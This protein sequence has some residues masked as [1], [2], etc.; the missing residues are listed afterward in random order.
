MSYGYGKREDAAPSANGG[1]SREELPARIAVP[2]RLESRPTQQKVKED[3]YPYYNPNILTVT[4]G[5]LTKIPLSSLS[6]EIAYI[7]S[8]G[9]AYIGIRLVVWANTAVDAMTWRDEL[10]FQQT[11]IVLHNNNLRGSPGARTWGLTWPDLEL[12]IAGSGAAHRVG[13]YVAEL[14]PPTG[15][16]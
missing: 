7:L 2:R 8:T 1:T 12:T 5:V 15:W 6:G 14:I 13:W 3:L 9:A 16:L 11:V 4:P 10:L